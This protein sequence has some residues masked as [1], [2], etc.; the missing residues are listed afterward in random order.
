[1]RH[2]SEFR[3]PHGKAFRKVGGRGGGDWTF[4]GRIETGLLSVLAG[5]HA[6]APWRAI[7]DEYAHAGPPATPFGEVDAAHW[8]ARR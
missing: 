7:R 1:L 5:F 8:R 6:T 3:S 2:Q 4:V